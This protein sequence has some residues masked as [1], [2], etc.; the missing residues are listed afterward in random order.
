MINY[1]NTNIASLRLSN[2]GLY[3]INEERIYF[4]VENKSYP[5]EDISTEKWLDIL[6]E[7]TRFSIKNNMADM[8]DLVKYQRKVTYQLLEHFSTDEKTKLMLEYETKFGKLL[9]NEDI[10]LMENWF[11][12]AWNWIKGKVSSL[13]EKGLKYGKDLVDCIGR[14]GC[15]PLFE[16]FREMLYS[17]VGISIDIFLSAT[18]YG[19][20]GLIIVWAIMALW[21][22]YLLISGQPEADWLNLIFDIVGIMSG[23][24][25]KSARTAVKAAGM[26]GKG[27]ELSEIIETGI[28][29]PKTKGIFTTIYNF[30]KNATGKISKWIS[31]AGKFLSEKL[32][33]K[34]M[35]NIVKKISV[36]IDKILNKFNIFYEPSLTVKGVK[37]AGSMYPISKGIDIA[38]KPRTNF[39]A[40]ADFSNY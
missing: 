38:T 39:W 36:F 32:G 8:P 28:K 14:R 20:I 40:D 34:F 26:T 35:N 4:A 6:S 2:N 29:N 24:F 10:L 37:Q 31:Q 27:K 17:P 16:D 19:K 5:L 3:L 11:D 21:D 12:N 23:V 22:T 9:L 13:G 1:P 18:G 25:A 7:N 15:S 33:M 30:L